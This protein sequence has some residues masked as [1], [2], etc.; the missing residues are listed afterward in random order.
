M[1]VLP[2]KRLGTRYGPKFCG[3]RVYVTINRTTES[4]FDVGSLL[5]V[6][7]PTP[8][9]LDVG[10]NAFNRIVEVF[11]DVDLAEG[12]TLVEHGH[13]IGKLVSHALRAGAKLDDIIG[14]LCTTVGDPKGTVEDGPDGVTEAKSLADLV[15]QM[16]LWEQRT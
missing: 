13:L 10:R 5:A 3:F 2:K 8:L 1:I 11:V 14:D 15:G 9:L 7:G 4:T 12:T 6:Q 16:L